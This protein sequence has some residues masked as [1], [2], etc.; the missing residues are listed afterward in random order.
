[1]INT[2]VDWC[3]NAT[4][5]EIVVLRGILPSNF[6]LPYLLDRKAVTPKRT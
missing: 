4:V 1:M 5:L 6:S 2:I 3:V